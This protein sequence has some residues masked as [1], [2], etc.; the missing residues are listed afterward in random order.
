MSWIEKCACVIATG[1]GFGYSPV[2]SGTVGALWGIPLFWL[3]STISRNTFPETVWGQYG[4]YTLLVGVLFAVGVWASDRMARYWQEKD[5]GRVVIDEI[6]GYLLTMF[7]LPASV[8]W[9]VAGF[10]VCR[11]LDIIKPW[12]AGWVDKNCP[13]GLG[14]MLDDAV[15]G[16]QGAVLLHLAKA[17]F[18]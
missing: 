17:F 4:V 12:P 15:S 1:L 8:S 14:I 11:I 9:M 10:I 3:F 2:A 16:L 7:A 6:V 13:S 18:F 5:P